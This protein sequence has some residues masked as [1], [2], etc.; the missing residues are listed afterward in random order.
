MKQISPWTES[1]VEM[2]VKLWIID[3]KSASEIAGIIGGT[4]RHAVRNKLVSLGIKRNTTEIPRRR[5]Y[6]PVSLID[7]TRNDCRFPLWGN[8]DAPT[9]MFC[10][11]SVKQGSS[12]CEDHHKQTHVSFRK[13][14]IYVPQEHLYKQ[15]RTSPWKKK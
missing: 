2:I 15:E 8:H 10:G 14:E 6:G 13:R 5:R 4:T 1:R 11:H 7:L 12:Y 3:K 9:G